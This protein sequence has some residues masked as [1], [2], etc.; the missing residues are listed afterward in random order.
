MD[1]T[2]T[3]VVVARAADREVLAGVLGPPG[4]Q[5]VW[6]ND[7]PEALVL[8]AGGRCDLALLDV[9][10]PGVDALG[11]LAQLKCD[12]HLWHVPVMVIAG[13]DEVDA[14]ADC[15]EAGADEYVLRPLHP[16]LVR[17]R[18]EAFLARR[19]FQD[20]E[21][22]YLKIFQ[23]QATDFNELTRDLAQRARHQA[24]EREPAEL[25]DLTTGGER[26]GLE[27]GPIESGAAHR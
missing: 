8:L 3:V 14:V 9:G 15:L 25:V 2:V 24:T 10:V 26:P 21:A 19:R 27:T 13:A 5:M 22:E 7:A 12:S 17:C 11:L 23:Q 4:A 20:L 18:L 1:G 6:A 16:V